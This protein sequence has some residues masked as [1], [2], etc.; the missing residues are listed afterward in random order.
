M[1]RI[2]MKLKK[3]WLPL[4]LGTVVCGPAI[5]GDV[6]RGASVF[7]AQCMVCH[8]SSASAA[9]GVG[10]KLFGVV[11]RRAGTVAGYNYSPAMMRSGLTWT[12]SQLKL[13]IAD[14]RKTV[15]GN[16]MPYMGLH[17][18]GLVESLV[19]YLATLR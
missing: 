19:D 9:S 2:L 8:A 6:S 3:V 4:I 5:A 10:P 11:G 17:D 1:A 15:P 13:Y 12:S 18:A 7:K 16:K 14:P